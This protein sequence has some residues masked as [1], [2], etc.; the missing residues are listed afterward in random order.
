M[1]GCKGPINSGLKAISLTRFFKDLL[2]IDL[3]NIN[4]D[5]AIGAKD[6]NSKFNGLRWI[7]PFYFSKDPKKELQLLKQASL[8][9]SNENENEIVVITHY[10]FF[11]TLSQKKI[12]IFNRWYFPGNNTHPSTNKNKFY[13]YYIDKLN[14]QI[15]DN[16]IK[17]IFLVKSHPKE[18]NF[19]KF[20]DILK[21]LCYEKKI[22]NEIFLSINIKKCSN[23]K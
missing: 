13:S 2:L 22:Y 4:L 10:Q 12:R 17:K 15:I 21:N 14:N 11:S 8:I 9:I 6:L 5:N 18:F 16:D 3:Q 1:F 7:T 19:I 20:E 23:Q